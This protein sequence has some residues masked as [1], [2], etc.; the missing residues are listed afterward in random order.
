MSVSVWV[1]DDL[2][3]EGWRFDD[4]VN[5][6][7]AFVPREFAGSAAIALDFLDKAYGFIPKKQGNSKPQSSRQILERIVLYK[8]EVGR[9]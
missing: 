4:I 2:W 9:V 8:K 6:R 5:C 7:Y 3:E 1:F